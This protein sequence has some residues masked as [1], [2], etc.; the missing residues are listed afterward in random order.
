MLKW[1]LPDLREDEKVQNKNRSKTAVVQA[2]EVTQPLGQALHR[3]GIR[4][5]YQGLVSIPYPKH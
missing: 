4:L 2:A 1:L 5:L 3:Q